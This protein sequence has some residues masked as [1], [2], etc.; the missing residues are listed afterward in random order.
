MKKHLVGKEFLKL[1]RP[2][3]C[4]EPKI[5]ELF[6]LARKSV[7]HLRGNLSKFQGQG[8]KISSP[9]CPTGVVHVYLY[10]EVT[11]D[12]VMDSISVMCLR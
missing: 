7:L 5:R 11:S 1:S 3:I 12:I 9:V 8:C 2:K 10:V 4:A 6:Y